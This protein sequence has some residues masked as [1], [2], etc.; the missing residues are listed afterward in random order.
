MTASEDQAERWLQPDA[1]VAV[2]LTGLLGPL[3]GAKTELAGQIL[4]D[5][6]GHLVPVRIF[7]RRDGTECRYQLVR[8]A[9]GLGRLEQ[10][11]LISVFGAHK[12]RGVLKSR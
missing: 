3:R 12:L 4:G 10:F 6:A 5:R 2:P 9:I 11:L 8:S 1:A 7:V